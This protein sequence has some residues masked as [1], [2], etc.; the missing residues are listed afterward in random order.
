[1]VVKPLGEANPWRK[2][3]NFKDLTHRMVRH[4]VFLTQETPHDLPAR[5]CGEEVIFIQKIFA[6]S[7]LG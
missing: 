6:D 7:N 5:E 2:S 4:T 3:K 1:M